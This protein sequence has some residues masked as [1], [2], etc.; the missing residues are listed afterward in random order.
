MN[1]FKHDLILAAPA[2]KVYEALTTQHGIQNWWTKSSEVGTTVGE[3]ITIRFGQT[4]KVMRIEGLRPATEVRWN[5]IDAH[6]VAPGL[7]RVNEWIGTTILFLLTPQSSTVTRVQLEHIGLTPQVECYE[8]CSQG[9]NQFLGSLQS[10]V[11]TG[12]GSPYIELSA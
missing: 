12:K 7:T 10:Y 3:T 4:F 11:E 6:L 9:W 8:I 5:V 1:S 2:M